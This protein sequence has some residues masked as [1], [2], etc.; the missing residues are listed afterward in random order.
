M[1]QEKFSYLVQIGLFIQIYLRLY[2]WTTK[3]YAQHIATGDLYA[4]LDLLIDQ[5]VEVFSGKGDDKNKYV[6]PSKVRLGDIEVHDKN[7]LVIALNEYK[8]ELMNFQFE[9]KDMKNTDL[10]NIRDEMVAEINRTLYLLKLN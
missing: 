10:Q 7:K 8:T 5:L 3:S 1:D 9:I 4:K 2:H 6:P